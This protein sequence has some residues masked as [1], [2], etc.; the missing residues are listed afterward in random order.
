MNR[1]KMKVSRE[2]IDDMRTELNT[3]G[4]SFDIHSYSFIYFIFILTCNIEDLTHL[5]L[6]F[7]L[8]GDLYD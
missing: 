5:K 8:T 2:L 4:V 3:I 7:N 6:K 1:Y